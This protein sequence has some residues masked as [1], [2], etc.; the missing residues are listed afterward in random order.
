MLA[1]LLR[2]FLPLSLLLASFTFAT[3]QG[4]EPDL[5]PIIDVL[6]EVD[7]PAVQLDVLRGLREGLKGR[8]DAKMP[9]GWESLYAKLS[10]SKNAEIREHARV[11]AL[12]FGDPQA[13]ADLR[14]TMLKANAPLGERLDALEVLVQKRVP[15]LVPVLYQ[16]LDDDKL[17]RPVIRS[18]SAY[19]DKDTPRVLLDRY[20]KMSLEEKQDTVGTL[21]AR[22]AFALALLDAVEAKKLPRTDVSAFAARQIYSLGDAKVVDRLRKVWGEVRETPKQKQEQIV[23][24]K[25]ILAPNFMKKAN[26]SNGRGVFA[27]TCQQ[28]HLLYGEGGKIGPDLTGANRGDLDYILHNIIDPSAAIAEDYRM[29]VVVMQDGRVLNGLIVERNNNSLT[30]QLVNEKVTVAKGDIDE[31][32]AA[33]QSM[34]PE[35]QLEKMAREEIR[36]LIAYLASKEQVPLPKG[37][38]LEKK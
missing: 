29:M 30:L 4:A 9:A 3:S 26:L 19:G 18:L 2:Y 27:K 14:Q 13:L 24:L 6:A 21:S 5:K 16:L 12:L 7:D 37:F 25:K 17:R 33:P 28:C 10:K 8:K 15:D 36:D 31:V 11:L 34:M 32:R 38:K 20:A 35:G 22:P 1:N 23:Q